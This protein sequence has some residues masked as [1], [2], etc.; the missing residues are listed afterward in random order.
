[1][2]KKNLLKGNWLWRVFLLCCLVF[3]LE[4]ALGQEVTISGTVRDA[5]FGD[6]LP[7]ASVSIKGTT[8][9]VIT[10]SDGAYSIIAPGNGVLVYSFIGMR[11]EE[12]EI[13][14]RLRIDVVLVDEMIN[15]GEVIVVGYGSQKKESVT[16]AISTINAREL[17]Q[18]PTANISNSLAG[19]LSGLTSVQTTGKPGED[20]ADLYVRGVGTYTGNSSPLIMVDGVE[21]ESYNDIDPNDIENISILKDAS[22]TAVFGVRGANGVILI[23]TKRGVVG[24]P[25]VSLSAQTAFSQFT[26]MPE[27]LGAYEWASLKNEQAY[28]QYWNNHANDPGLS[29]DQFV[30]N[31]EANWFNET[32]GPKF[33]EDELRYFK[34][35][36]TPRLDDG[37]TNPYYSP[38]LYPDTDWQS[39]IFKR[40]SRQSQYNLNITGGTNS[41][42]Y[43]ISLGHLD[44]G[45]LLETDYLPF[46]D[47][48]QYSK[49][50]Y[51]VRGNFDFD[52][53]KDFRISVDIG[54]QFQ[55][56]SG[57]TGDEHLWV[58]RI[59]WANPVTT[60][61]MIDGKFV[62]R[63]DATNVA[64]N[65]MY[66]MANNNFNVTN[67]STLNSSIKLS[68]KLDFI[69]QGLSINARVAYDSYFAS[70]SGGG[71]Y[72]PM[73]YRMSPNPNGDQLD[74]I[75]E[76]MNEE[77]TPAYFSDWYHRKW[78]KIYSEASFNYSREFGH[79]DLGALTLVNIEKKHDPELEYNLPHAYVGL[80]GR[81]TYA[82]AGKYLAEYNMGYNGSENFAE[83]KRF[84]FLPA[85]S[86]GWIISNEA[87]Y[88]QNNV[89]SYL[90]VRGSMGKVGNDNIIV[91]KVS[92]R[93]LYLPDVWEYSGG[94]NF[95]DLN[96]RSWVQG[97]VEGTLGNP[98]LTWETATKSNI[99]FETRIWGNRLSLTYDYFNEHRVDILSYR[100]TVPGIVQASL[101]PYNL[102]EVKNW[103]NEIEFHW[104][105]KIR[106][107]NYWIKGNA[108]TNKNKVVFMDEA[109]TP[110]LE[111]QA[112]TG[113]PINQGAYLIDDGLYTSWSDLYEL[114][115]N[116]NPIL[117]NPVLALNSDGNPYT[118]S[119]GLPVYQKDLGY[120]GAPVQPGEIRLLD[121]NEDGVIDDRDYVRTGKTNIPEFT[122]G[123]SMGFDFK[124]FDFS[125]LFQGVEGVERFVQTAE[126][127][128]FAVNY[129]LQEV[130][131]YRFTEERFK[132][133]ERIE[134]PIAG[135][136]SNVIRNTFF[137]KDASYLRLKNLEVGY[138]L[139][140]RVLSRVGL[141]SA[142]V[143]INGSNL[144][145]W[146]PNKIWGDPEN[147]GYVGYPI[148]RVYNIGLKVGF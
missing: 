52:V 126:S 105:D 72:T 11:T 138:S 127:K 47:D 77:D 10:N 113:R 59:M 99:G 139:P 19:R 86:L 73:L 134:F 18:S 55:T 119:D 91:D 78:R 140:K 21:R 45:G 70:R 118:N 32:T 83:G 144:L 108:S 88:P 26:Q 46:P 22:A 75:L 102:G 143:Y 141:E 84:G 28:Q 131:R 51:N 130:D 49:K 93:F 67:G 114:D 40:F 4:V 129:G 111:Y 145:T 109:I 98:N 34:N 56:V 30:T 8:R 135:Y 100:G 9:G 6:V 5:T 112:R 62:V 16:G 53:T 87:F 3:P 133:G 148:T 29:W 68:H 80:V 132:A 92:Q 42:K 39:M 48:M 20:M 103:G 17:T 116:G 57:M 14:N 54:T 71:N 76:K 33:T 79:H 25:K 115:G 12:V 23:T 36:N 122:Y 2:K 63:N 146:A 43:F 136:N 81:I 58:K 110:G 15:V 38:Y 24:A 69:T 41:V 101:P 107:F 90:K 65:V 35:A 125:V 97:A 61:G 66:E 106:T 74:P 124:G 85:Y 13:N 60:P 27:F 64:N 82:Y 121:I 31:R 89:L 1:M 37:S 96:N 7:G 120:G 94:Y 95:G 123:V 142:R 50:R 44:Q 128:H 137:L 147:M 104:R 117:A